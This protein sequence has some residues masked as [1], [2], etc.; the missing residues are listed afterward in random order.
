MHSSLTAQNIRREMTA[1]DTA[2]PVMLPTVVVAGK[3]MA[4]QRIWKRIHDQYPLPWIIR[5]EP[6]AARQ[7]GAMNTDKDNKAGFKQVDLTGAKVT[8]QLSLAV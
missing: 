1:L 8:G 7:L 4:S 5:A 3:L 2:M 6:R